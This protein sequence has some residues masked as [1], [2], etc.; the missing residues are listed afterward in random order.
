MN[1]EFEN[2]DLEYYDY[3]EQI[4]KKKKYGKKYV[5]K[6]GRNNADVCMY[7]KKK[8]DKSLRSRTKQK[9]KFVDK[10]H[11]IITPKEKKLESVAEHLYLQKFEKM[12]GKYNIF[13][14]GAN[15]ANQCDD[16]NCYTNYD[17]YAFDYD[18]SG[19]V[20]SFNYA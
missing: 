18:S 2:N 1:G 11:E 13:L 7:L 4:P 19:N 6:N 16:R 17:S 10:N 3:T 14:H 12:F 9:D 20:I 8:C 15:P 5:S